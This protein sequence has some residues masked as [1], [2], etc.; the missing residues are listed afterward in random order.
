MTTRASTF[1]FARF[2]AAG[3]DDDA[4][5]DADAEQEAARCPT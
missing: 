4:N 5:A 3:S 1:V 2:S